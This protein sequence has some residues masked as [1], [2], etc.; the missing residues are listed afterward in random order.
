M[1]SRG[2][3]GRSVLLPMAG[4]VPSFQEK[5]LSLLEF[6][7]RITGINHN[8]NVQCTISRGQAPITKVSCGFPS[9]VMF[10]NSNRFPSRFQTLYGFSI[11]D[12]SETVIIIEFLNTGFTTMTLVKKLKINK[13]C[14]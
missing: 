3:P 5:Y 11:H 14:G 10:F 13:S 6:T 12:P 7:N 2:H 8:N 4:M 1:A 9:T